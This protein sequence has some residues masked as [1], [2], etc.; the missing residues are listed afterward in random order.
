MSSQMND[1]MRR[2]FNKLVKLWVSMGILGTECTTHPLLSLEKQRQ[3]IDGEE[4][5]WAGVSETETNNKYIADNN[6]QSIA[7]WP[8]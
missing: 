4:I 7:V 6:K 2:E 3:V 1:S 5:F 8:A